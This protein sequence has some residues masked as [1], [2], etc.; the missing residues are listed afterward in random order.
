LE[1]TK[2]KRKWYLVALAVLIIVILSSFVAYNSFLKPAAPPMVLTISKNAE[3]DTL[4]P[5]LTGM[6][7]GSR[8]IMTMFDSYLSFDQNNQ[9]QPWLAE[10]WQWSA[11]M[12]VLTLNLRKDVKFHNGEPFNATA[13]KYSI[14]RILDPTMKSPQFSTLAEVDKVD[15]LDTYKVAITLKAPNR[16][17]LG[18]LASNT[19]GAPVCPDVAKKLGKDYGT[20][21]PVGTG[22]FMFK[23]WRRDDRVVLVRNPNYNWAPAFT[24]HTGPALLDQIIFKVIPEDTTRVADVRTPSGSDMMTNVPEN[25]VERLRADPNLLVLTAP[26]PIIQFFSF[27]LEHVTDVNIR[28]AVAYAI[29]RDAINKAIYFGLRQPAYSPMTPAHGA[30]FTNLTKTG[31]AIPY[32]PKKAASILDDNGWKLGSD[33][34]RYKDGKILELTDVQYLYIPEMTIVQDSLKKVGIKMNLITFQGDRQGW[35]SRLTAGTFDVT[36]ALYSTNVPGLEW[37]FFQQQIPWPNWMRLRSPEFESLVSAGKQNPDEK[38]AMEA[39]NKAVL[40]IVQQ[41]YW[42]PLFYPQ[43]IVVIHKNIQNYQLPT[44]IY[45]WMFLDVTVR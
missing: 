18:V 19:A 2:S 27:D 14:D 11:D 3:A 34:Y 10:S 20:T 13:V 42:V 37:F 40:M 8:V 16:F 31:Q 12:K 38:A 28:L 23:E 26:Q 33:G 15:I 29:D 17:F 22:P 32:D 6:I 41:A 24:H 7:E 4:D 36:A 39:E 5:G 30:W 35:Y 43:N 44:F 1:K 25:Q 45:G 9:I 21:N